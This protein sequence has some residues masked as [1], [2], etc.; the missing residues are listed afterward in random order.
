MERVGVMGLYE[1]RFLVSQGQPFLFVKGD[2]SQNRASHA[3][4]NIARMKRCTVV[5]QGSGPSPVMDVVLQ[6]CTS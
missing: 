5:W 3:L 1:I 4:V 2:R 6:D